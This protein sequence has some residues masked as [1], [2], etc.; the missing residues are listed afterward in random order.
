VRALLVQARG[1]PD[2]QQALALL[3]VGRGGA[4]PYRRMN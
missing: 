3:R 4:L 1:L 2:V